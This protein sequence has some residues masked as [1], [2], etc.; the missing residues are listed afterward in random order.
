MI[1]AGA[2]ESTSQSAVWFTEVDSG[3]AIYDTWVVGREANGQG[4]GQFHIGYGRGI[5]GYWW[6]L[7]NSKFTIERNRNVGIGTVKPTE[8]LDVDGKGH[9]SEG[10]VVEGTATI[11]GDALVE[12]SFSIGAIRLTPQKGRPKKPQSGMIYFDDDGHFYGYTGEGWK[13]LDNDD[14]KDKEDKK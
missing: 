2:R 5:A 14:K 11:K 3:G 7:P 6:N 9:F 1:L 12:G 4:D 10:V 8:K 13:K